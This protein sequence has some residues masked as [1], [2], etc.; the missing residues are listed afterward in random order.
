MKKIKNLGVLLSIIASTLVQN[1]TIA[2][3]TSEYGNWFYESSTGNAVNISPKTHSGK[4]TVFPGTGVQGDNI[5]LNFTTKEKAKFQKIIEALK[6]VNPKPKYHSM[7]YW[8]Y[9]QTPNGWRKLTPAMITNRQFRFSY[10]IGLQYQYM[11]FDEGKPVDQFFALKF[12]REWDFLNINI[13]AIPDFLGGKAGDFNNRYDGPRFEA[14]NDFTFKKFAGDRAL[15]MRGDEREKYPRYP[16]NEWVVSIENQAG[17]FE[18]ANKELGEDLGV[19]S[20]DIGNEADKHFVYRRFRSSR[21]ISRKK[22]NDKLSRHEVNNMVILSYNSQLPFKPL[23]IGR[24]I[25]IGNDIVD[26]LIAN[27]NN[28]TDLRAD[29]K[30]EILENHNN[31]KRF[32]QGLR[33]E[34]A[35]RLNE[36]AI[37]DNQYS[38]VSDLAGGFIFNDNRQ[39]TL[40]ISNSI[41]NKREAVSNVLSKF[42]VTETKRGKAF[43]SYDNEFYKGMA[44]G[45]IRTICV[46][47]KDYIRTTDHRD[48][49]KGYQ[50]EEGN[51]IQNRFSDNPDHYL[52]HFN[53]KFDWKKLKALLGK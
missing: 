25:E 42:F 53:K 18:R 10:F 52:Y 7:L 51:V 33:T 16:G 29:I 1:Y 9:P 47:W 15:P 17:S 34:Y 30:Q 24:F 28:K 21:S 5:K 27:Y 2:Q 44:D 19:A 6:E 36:Q 13:N 39:K 48:Y 49:G 31:T 20:F 41:T 14:E 38:H 22:E 11:H 37:I 32:L 45:E 3:T 46:I 12:G 43:Y 23:T 26:E 4:P 50:M 8:M 35:N 40:E